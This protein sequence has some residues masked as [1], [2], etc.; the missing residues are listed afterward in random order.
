MAIGT[1]T[2]KAPFGLLGRTLGHSWSPWI[3]NLLGSAPY[4][5]FE[6]EPEEVANFI[7]HGTW[8]GINVTIPYKRNAFELADETSDRA[9]RLGVAN[10]SEERV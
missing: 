10:R 6:R 8:R 3:H 5:L 9:A 2:D 7:R 1:Q 4:A